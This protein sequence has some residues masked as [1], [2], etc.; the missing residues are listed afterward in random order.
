MILNPTEIQRTASDPKVSAWVSASAGT[1]KTKILSDRVL[2]LLLA[3]NDPEKI[4]CM[5]YT[6]SASAEMSD[7]LFK[8]LSNWVAASDEDLT[9]ALIDLNGE[10]PDDKTRIRA[11]QLFALVLEAKGGMKIMTFHSFCQSLLKR[12]PIEAGVSPYFDVADDACSAELLNKAARQAFNNP[13][14]KEAFRTLADYLDDQSLKKLLDNMVKDAFLL[15]ESFESFPDKKQFE[16]QLRSRLNIDAAFPPVC[17]IKRVLPEEL[18]PENTGTKDKTTSNETE[19]ALF[20]KAFNLFKFQYINKT[21][22]QVPAKCSAE[23]RPFTEQVYETNNKL[24]A[25]KIYDLTLAVVK[26]AKDILESYKHFKEQKG[27]LDYDDLIFNTRTLLEKSD[28]ASWVLYKLDG[29]IDHI[30][31]DEAQ[32]TGPSQWAVL[33]PITEEFFSGK[34]RSEKNRTLFV[35]GDRKQS[36]YS[37]QNAD[38][39]EFEKMRHFFREKIQSALGKDSFREVPLNISF[40][41]TQSVLD[42][43]NMVLK[44]DLSKKGILLENEEALHI[45]F[46]SKA[47]GRVE[48]YPLIS[49][50]KT[51]EEEEPWAL[52]IKKQK[53]TT[54]ALKQTAQNIADK[55]EQLI[56]GKEILPSRGTPI[57]PKDIMILVRKR[58]GDFINTLVRL[59][60]EKNIPV[61]GIDRLALKE[62]T[63]VIDLLS[64]GNFLLLPDDDLTLACLLK[65]PLFNVTEEELFDLCVNRGN[66]SLYQQI[67]IQNEKLYKDLKEIT[68]MTDTVTP[69]ALF[70][71]VLGKK[72]GKASFLKRLGQDAEEA[73]DEFLNLALDYE[74]KNTPSLQAFIQWIQSGD[75]IIKRDL[76]Q[77][78]LNAVRIMTV[79]GSKGLQGNIVFLPDTRGRLTTEQYLFW[80]NKIPVYVPNKNIMPPEIQQQKEKIQ[81]SAQ[82]EYRRLLYVALTRA[83]DRLYIYGYDKKHKAADYNWYDMIVSSVSGYDETK[84][85]ILFNEQKEAPSSKEELQKQQQSPISKPD[86]LFN[87]PQKAQDP[88]QL[89]YPSRKAQ[90]EQT[91]PSPVEENRATALLRGTYMHLLLQKLPQISSDKWEQAAQNLRPEELPEEQAATGA[92]KVFKLL[93]EDRFKDI[94]GP[95]SLAEAPLIG[96]IDDKLFSGRVDRLAV[97]EKEVLVIDYK[98]NQHPP[99]DKN[100]IPPLYKE[101]V[102]AYKEILKNIFPDKIIRP[103]LL[104]TETLDLMEL[105]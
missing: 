55:I 85:Y 80:L 100:N 21:N 103:F 20:E 5:T 24:K 45:P 75:I 92:K 30:L 91:S 104:W 63:A 52:P 51:Q 2:R 99:K 29:G 61:A 6:N 57:E 17:L 9:K 71:Y 60:K 26:V 96:K 79:H 37:F 12:F 34:G 38:P 33:R 42:L 43:V 48:I 93:K 31:V 39:D 3:D 65:S 44:N 23:K 87:P 101:Q 83:S 90:E 66:N 7:R 27:V 73:L 35:V 78:D 50:E 68:D 95:D 82:E 69:F 77:G 22:E 58:S 98:T 19:A 28:M 97:K 46:R 41:S 89:L 15:R 18:Y 11:R 53:E 88:F 10:I 25:W 76:E 105:S 13:V 1:G 40:R 102:I 70:S 16:A 84:P 49:D 14:L 56:K 64:L 94:F 59:L 32:D 36:I 72:G 54:L 62:H 47:A 81:Q 4:L 86:W 8:T 67:K 74:Q